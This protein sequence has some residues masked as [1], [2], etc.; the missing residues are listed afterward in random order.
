LGIGYKTSWLAVRHAAPQDVADALGLV[1]CEAMDWTRGTETAYRRGVYVARPHPEWTIAHSRIH[2]PVEA[3][4]AN[5]DFPDWLLAL[6]AN[7]GDLQFFATDRIGD[8]HAWARVDAGRLTRAY[9]YIG[10]IGEV[11]LHIGERGAIEV[12]L[13]IGHRWLEDGWRQWQESEWDEWHA[14]MPS[15]RHVMAIARQWSICPLD[16]P[17]ESVTDPGIYGLTPAVAA[18]EDDRRA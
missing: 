3:D 1:Q 15:E 12:E 13:G 6:S 14:A 4:A 10:V 8:Y 18:V 16:I 2:L 17:E 7:L 11:P 9:C 5:P